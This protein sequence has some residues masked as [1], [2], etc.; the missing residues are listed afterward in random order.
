MGNLARRAQHQHFVKTGDGA[1]DDDAGNVVAEK[2]RQPL[3]AGGLVQHGK[4]GHLHHAQQLRA[5]IA[6]KVPVPGQLQS[7]AVDVGDFDVQPAVFGGDD[8]LEIEGLDQIRFQNHSSTSDL[9]AGE[10]F[11]QHPRHAVVRVC[12]RVPGNAREYFLAAVCHG[13]ALSGIGEHAQIVVRVAKGGDLLA[14]TPS[15]SATARR[16]LPLSTSPLTIS[17]YVGRENISFRPGKASQTASRRPR[18][19]RAC[20]DRAI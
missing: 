19:A 16:A 17:R 14:R 7:G 10:Q 8:G 13:I 18:A 4:V 3:V 15:C 11:F 12:P 9:A 6:E 1:G 2:A 5:L 20:P